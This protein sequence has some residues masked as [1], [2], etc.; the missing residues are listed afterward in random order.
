MASILPIGDRWRAQIRRAGAKSISRT[1]PSR[2]EAEVWAREVEHRADRGQQVSAQ[3]VGVAWL[4]EHYEQ[5]REEAG[6][7]VGKQS[8]EHYMLKRLKN[9]F[10]SLQLQKL[11]TG[12]IRDYSRNR[13]RQG[14]GPYSVNMELS[15]LGTALRYACSLLEIPF[16]DPVATARPTLHHLG[17]IGSGQKRVR[18]PTP[19]EWTKLLAHLPSLP[20]AVPMAD[21]VRVAALSALRRGEICRIAWADLDV[22]R[23]TVL[24]RD[25]KHPRRK[26]GNNEEVPLI[27]DSLDIVMRQPRH[28]REPRIFPYEPGTV[29]YWFTHACKALGIADLHLHDMRHEAT[30]A[31]FEAGW[32][33]PEVAAVTGHKDWRHLK[34]Y[35]H[36]DPAAIARKPR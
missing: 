27:G 36:P 7:P 33:I 25:R 19:D 31:L 4:L 29:S 8:N 15:K 21:I 9:H 35:T 14:A 5:A 28:E 22:E 11:T 26:Q 32:Q 34:R 6:R 17:L 12:E 1:F 30:S 23:R 13:R 18:R 20:T 24:V 2:R 3:K 10:G 16:H